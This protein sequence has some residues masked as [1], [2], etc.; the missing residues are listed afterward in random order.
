VASLSRVI[1]IVP[2]LSRVSRVSTWGTVPVVLLSQGLINVG[3][4]TYGVLYNLYLAAIGQSL[5]FIGTFNAVTLLAIGVSAIPIGAGARRI[6]HLAALGAGTLLIVATQVVVTF[7]TSTWILLIAAAIWG[8]AQALASVPVGPL[9][10]E[11]VPRAERARVFGQLYAT[12]SFAT[13]IG[14]VLGGTLPVLLAAVLSIGPASGLG[15]YRGALLIST[16]ITF[17]GWPLLLRP[18][19][20]GIEEAAGAEVEQIQGRS[21]GLRSVRHTLGVV[22][23][24]IGI[25]SFAG[26][27][28][29]PFF[30][31]YFA[32][33]LHMAT[34]LIGILFAVA[35]VLS[36]I[37]SLL[38]PRLSRRWG[39]VRAVTVVRLAIVPCLL[40]LSLGT[41][42]ALLA[43]LG[44]LARFALVFTS[45]ALD[46]HFTLMSVPVGTRPFAAGLRTGAFNLFWALGSWVSGELLGRVGFTAMFLTSATL[47]MITVLLF[48]A[49]FGLPLQRSA[50]R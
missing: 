3:L 18:A 36:T 26:G 24:T 40:G 16:A 32:E 38:G 50:R 48:L 4:A 39:S 8:V 5:A 22:A 25:Y 14:S 37:G 30:N 23:V 20:R 49:L 7:N 28:V 1:A 12:W 17:L 27:L 2:A 45:G 29:A 34:T 6:S 21:W 43:V 31:I 13:V 19:S 10:S 41:Q 42:I 9:L 47:T 35:A 11:S 33:E 15:A 44:F 46:S